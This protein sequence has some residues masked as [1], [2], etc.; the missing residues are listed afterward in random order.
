[1]LSS[2]WSVPRSRQASGANR[3]T[4]ALSSLP[5]LAVE[6]R[7][8]RIGTLAEERRELVRPAHD[9]PQQSRIEFVKSLAAV[10]AYPDE[11]G[12]LEHA[13]VLLDGGEYHSK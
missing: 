12:V 6:V 7:A 8:E 10:A 4:A 9:V 3:D 1:M 5:V 2:L 13:Q 11:V